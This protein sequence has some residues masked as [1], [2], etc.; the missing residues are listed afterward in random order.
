ME[1][2]ERKIPIHEQGHTTYVFPSF[3]EYIEGGGS[4]ITFHFCSGKTKTVTGTLKEYIKILAAWDFFCLIHRSFLVNTNE[5]TDFD[6]HRYF[7][8]Q[9]GSMVPVSEK[10]RQNLRERGFL[11]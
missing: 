11:L 1:T 3:I 10:G 5:I 9:S 2:R 8:L 6:T 4:Y 7:T